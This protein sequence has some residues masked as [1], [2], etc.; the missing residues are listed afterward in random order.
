MNGDTPVS[1]PDYLDPSLT[2]AQRVADLLPRMTLEEKAGLLFHPATSL[3]EPGLT[4]AEALATAR[5]DIADRFISHFN[6]FNGAD[7]AEIAAWSN[8]LQELAASTRLGIPITLSSDPR[9]GFH[10]TPF[11]GQTLDSLSRWP[12]HTGLGAIDDPEVARAYGD[13]I[14]R[15]FLAM[16]LRVYLGPMADIFSEPRWTRGFGTFGEDV[17]VV[18]RLTAAFIEGLRGS[19]EL[20]GESVAA[21]VKHFPG[22]GPQLHGDDAHDSRHPEQVYPGGRQ[23]LHLRPFEA[24]FGAGVTQLMTYYGMP[25]GTEWEERGFAFNRP[26]V[27]DLL[28]DHY[29]FTGI[30][31]SDW[32]V[33]DATE[34]AGMPFG[35]NGYGLLDVTPTDRLQ[36]ALEVGVDQFGGDTCTE[37]V[38]ELVRDGRISE[39]RIDESAARILNEKFA[40][41]LFEHRFV[42]V[43]A[44]RAIGSD[45]A[46]RARGESAQAASL[47]LLADEDALVPVAGGRRV[48]AEGIDWSTVSH[49]LVVADSPAEADLALVRLDAP[50][51]SD[52]DSPLGDFFHGGS[53]EFPAETV[54]QVAAIAEAVPTVVVV[55]LERPAVLTPLLPHAAA[56]VADFG[57]SD[58]VV[59][60][61][62]AGITGFAGRLPFD[63]PR[64]GAAVEASRE[65]VP[66]DTEEPVF[67]HGDGIARTARDEGRSAA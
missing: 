44:A 27:K 23:Q 25:V 7:A 4:E 2:P 19:A 41:G 47:V 1:T 29:G 66:F 45:P 40:L 53:L 21:V 37:R 36:V 42:D 52:P 56:L 58:Q 31:V 26:V 14:R 11:T 35:P 48:Y 61:A 46:L 49:D 63:L 34:I 57:A 51:Q 12:E 30:V 13:T 18:S 22:G 3:P 59:V 67:R 8:T 20:S 50:W 54:A 10:S 55:Y 32:N 38:V 43:D 6:V 28:R 33:I 17:D 15:E 24:A 65:D 9:S 16:G 62:V 39:A 5:E 60:D 64:S